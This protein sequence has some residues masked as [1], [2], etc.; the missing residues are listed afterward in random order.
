MIKDLVEKALKDES[1]EVRKLA[2]P[3]IKEVGSMADVVDLLIR[4]SQDGKGEV[5]KQ[6]IPIIHDFV[7]DKN[8]SSELKIKLLRAVLKGY[9]DVALECVELI[10]EI[11]DEKDKFALVELALSHEI[12]DVRKAAVSLIREI[13]QVEERR[14]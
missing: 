2:V 1:A 14:P 10:K 12:A 6:S 5:R 7:K 8:I 13:K 4:A 3:L 9:W 11:D